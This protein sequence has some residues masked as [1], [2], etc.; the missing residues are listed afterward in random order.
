MTGLL[1][2]LFYLGMLA[3]IVGCFVYLFVTR[4]ESS[5]SPPGEGEFTPPSRESAAKAEALS[6]SYRLSDLERIFEQIGATEAWGM[7]V[8]LNF[9]TA[10]ADLESIQ[11]IVL[12]NEVE[13]CTPILDPSYTDP[14]RRAVS[15][16]GLQAR[17]GYTEGQYCV[18]VNGTWPAIAG[19]IRRIVKSVHGVGDHEEVQVRIFYY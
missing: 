2:G 11:M 1:I 9:T 10:P 17:P 16:T 15:E 7:V 18:D 12:R 19:I 8:E 14:F 3:L 4:D 13:L 5:V 6:G